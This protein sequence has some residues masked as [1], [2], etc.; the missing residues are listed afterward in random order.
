MDTIERLIERSKRNRQRVILPEG[1]D[2]RILEAAKRLHDEGIAHPILVGER[3][4]LENEAQAAGFSLTGIESV[5][6]APGPIL[7]AYAALYVQGRPRA[8]ER[9]AMRF[10]SRPLHYA[11]MAVKAGAADLLV[12]GA[13]QPTARIIEAGLMTVGMAKGIAT[14]SS[15]FLMIPQRRP[16]DDENPDARGSRALIFADCAVNIDP[17]PEQLA[18]IAIASAASAKQLLD[19]PPRVAMLSFST[20]GSA[21]HARVEKVQ[22]A[23]E[24]ARKRAPGLAIDGEMQVDTALVADVARIKLEKEDLGDERAVAGRANILVFPDLDAGNIGY[25]L[26]E[27]LG[28]MRA[29]GPFLQGFAKPVCDLSRGASVD[30]IVAATAIS[31][32][33]GQGSIQESD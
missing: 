6:P 29:I 2:R 11:A 22:K 33:M 24:L 9:M 1:D 17:D 28:G 20:K 3:E 10:L 15:F 21:R 32:L 25:K 4:K 27:R 14:P 12:A 5:F 23:V 7:D 16:E 13:K 31:G 18:D 19:A 30:D 8:N 26:S